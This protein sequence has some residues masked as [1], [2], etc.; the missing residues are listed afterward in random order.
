[1]LKIARPFIIL[2]CFFVMAGC[3]ETE[4]TSQHK[5]T[6]SPKKETE[7]VKETKPTFR[8]TGEEMEQESGGELFQKYVIDKEFADNDIYIEAQDEAVNEYIQ[9]IKKEDTKIWSAEQWAGSLI[10]AFRT[11]YKTTLQP[12]KDYE[13]KFNKLKLPDGRLLQDVSEEELHEQ[14]D[15]VNVALLLDAS[16]SMKANVPGGNKMQLAKSSLSNFAQNLPD[17]TNVSLTVFGHKGTGSDKD[18][19]LSC[20]SVETVYPLNSYEKSKFST[21]LNNFKASGWT[22]LAS[23][24]EKVEQQLLAASEE[25]TK[26]FIY[27]VSDG[28]ETCGGNPVQAAKDAKASKMDIQINIIG[29]DVDNEADRQ[30][31]EVAK[32]GGGEYTSVRTKQQLDDEVA[33]NWREAMG[34]T[35]WRFWAVGNANNINWDSVDMSQQLQGLYN[36]NITARNRESDRINTALNKLLENRMIDLDKKSAISDILFKRSDNMRV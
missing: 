18:M 26:N 8:L 6:S 31:K 33:K 5:K 7:T 25:H 24:I 17:K 27:V 29:F 28:I 11:D 32:A 12:M 34:K 19:K 22:P 14:A 10:T 1:M 2:L 23:A 36:K 4:K 9:N 30:L 16:G 35:T 3:Q 15:K 21:A 13:V 20:G